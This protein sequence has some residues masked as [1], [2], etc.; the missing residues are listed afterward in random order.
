MSTSKR[1]AYLLII[2]ALSL[3]PIFSY[4]SAIH[5]IIIGDTQDRTIGKTVAIDIPKI[6]EHSK[7]IAA[8][9]N[10]ELKEKLLTGSNVTTKN[11]LETLET[12]QFEEDDAVILYYS[13]HGY[14]T[15][16]PKDNQWPNVALPEWKGINLEY[17][18]EILVNKNP[19]FI[20]AIADVCN[21]VIPEAF[22]P[23][24]LIKRE[25]ADENT[26][27]A[28]YI[29]LFLET[30]AVIIASGASPTLYAYCDEKNG[31][32]FTF[33]Y[34]RSLFE[35]MNKPDGTAEWE[36][37]FSKTKAHLFKQQQPQYQIIWM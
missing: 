20:L 24:T 29:K 27:K 10:L 17:M 28:N 11:I 23:P 1:G 7:K 14:R 15:S 6:R 34:L 32:H 3:M 35:E 37:I 9:T 5:S 26:I 21:N 30:K 13:G 19:R 25:L 12:I 22:A 16:N 8:Y 36:N 18:A 33:Y 4:C 2:T 31:G